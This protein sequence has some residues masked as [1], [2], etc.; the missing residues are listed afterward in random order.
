MSPAAQMSGDARASIEARVL[1]I[2]SPFARP[3]RWFSEGRWIVLEPPQG[4][5]DAK[6]LWYV[7]Q[8]ADTH[9]VEAVFRA[10]PSPGVYLR[11]CLRELPRETTAP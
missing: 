1:A 3:W 7:H 4:A 2:M 10:T 6:T 9:T 8:H 11:F 5:I